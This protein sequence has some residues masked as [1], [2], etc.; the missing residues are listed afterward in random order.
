MTQ[1]MCVDRVC[2]GLFDMSM[3]ITKLA[4]FEKQPR[5]GPTGGE[6]E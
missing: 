2:L 6:R 3:C 4:L 1:V 5:E